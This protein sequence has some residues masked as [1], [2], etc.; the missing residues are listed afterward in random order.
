MSEKITFNKI[1]EGKIIIIPNKDI[2]EINK[3]IKKEMK[4]ILAEYRSKLAKYK[5]EDKLKI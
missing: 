5:R 4:L 3:R 1:N 2:A